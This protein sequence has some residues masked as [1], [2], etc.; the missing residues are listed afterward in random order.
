MHPRFN[1]PGG[2][3]PPDSRNNSSFQVPHTLVDM[4]RG[5][6]VLRRG[7]V[8]SNHAYSR[9]NQSERDLRNS[10]IP[11]NQG[12]PQPPARPPFR[13]YPSQD[14]IS[15]WQRRQQGPKRGQTRKVKLT[16]GNFV[17]EYVIY[18]YFRASVDTETKQICCARSHSQ[19]L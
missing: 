7:D 10:A 2:Q 5:V 1:P 11:P 13:G 4:P 15:D 9:I 8:P 12:Y 18:T 19:H 16:K 17:A 3:R 14:S 6:P